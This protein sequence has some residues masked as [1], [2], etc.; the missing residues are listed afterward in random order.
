MPQARPHHD[1]AARAVR[2]AWGP[3]ALETGRRASTPRD[4]PPAWP[5]LGSMPL[6]CAG[7]AYLNRRDPSLCKQVDWSDLQALRE[8]C[9]SVHG[10]ILLAGLETA[11]VPSAN[12]KHLGKVFS[13]PSA[14]QS[15]LSD[16]QPDVAQELGWIDRRLRL[17]FARRHH[18][19]FRKQDEYISLFFDPL[20]GVDQIGATPGH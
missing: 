1:T 13:T 20:F 3:Q 16:S 8:P 14:T 15:Q 6:A 19:L 17:A 2:G 18:R 11:Y 7:S 9:E 10:E 5:P 12:S 4:P